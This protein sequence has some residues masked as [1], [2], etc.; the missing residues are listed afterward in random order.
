MRIDV[1]PGLDTLVRDAIA[2]GASRL[3]DLAVH[4]G[5]STQALTRLRVGL[6]EGKWSFPMCDSSERIIGVRLRFPNGGK[7]SVK[8]GREGL[9]LP[10]G[11]L[12]GYRAFDALLLP[13]GASDTAAI[14]DLGFEAVGR[15]N[16]RGGFFPILAL[17]RRLAVAR[18]VVVA[19]HDAAGIRGAFQLAQRLRAHCADIR[20]IAPPAGIKDAREWKA[21]G[22]THA[23]LARAIDAANPIGLSMRLAG[24][25]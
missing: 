14:L 24:D 19:D 13:E 17:I 18:A 6:H 8:G 10:T 16:D 11:L 23:D 5:V 3:D 9:F 4:L 15:P 12:Q 20:V 25:R 2:R 1:R 22:A 7:I 21:R